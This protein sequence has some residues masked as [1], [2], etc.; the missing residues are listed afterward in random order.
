MRGT[1]FHKPL[2]YN[3]FLPTQFSLRSQAAV[4]TEEKQ[5]STCTKPCIRAALTSRRWVCPK[6]LIVSVAL[7]LVPA[8]GDQSIREENGEML[9]TG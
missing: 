5:S 6:M 2:Y 3:L 8:L 1:A 4:V 7:R 9:Q